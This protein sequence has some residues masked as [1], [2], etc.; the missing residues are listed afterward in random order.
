MI[1]KCYVVSPRTGALCTI[2][3]G[4]HIYFATRMQGNDPAINQLFADR[5]NKLLGI[6]PAEAARMQAEVEESIHRGYKV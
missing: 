2:E 5:L 4:E 3:Q 1:Q 6:S